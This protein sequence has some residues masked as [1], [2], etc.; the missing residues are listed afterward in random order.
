MNANDVLIDLLEDNRRRL[1][2]TFDQLSGECLYWHPDR[3]TNSIAVTAWHMARIFDVFLTRQTKGLPAE[4]ES[5]F[6]HGWAERTGY[7]PRGLGRDGWGMVMGYTI[8]EMHAIPQFTRERLLGYLDQ[9]YD[10]V[11]DYV[12]ET[13]IEELLTP[14][15]GFDGKFSKYQIIQ[16]ALM[17]NV[18]HLGEITTLKA[19]WER[20]NR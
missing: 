2:R 19:R 20:G 5:W 8:E 17:D 1:K 18:R 11:K 6:K 13:P 14:A 10:A 9:V 15:P 7:D 12:R 3:E 4:E 16:M